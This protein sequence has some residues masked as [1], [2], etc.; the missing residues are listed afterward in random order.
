[1]D[2]P[3][4]MPYHNYNHTAGLQIFVS[5]NSWNSVIGSFLEVDPLHAWLNYTNEVNGTALNTTAADL[6]QVFQQL[7]LG[8]Q[9]VGSND[10]WRFITTQAPKSVNEMQADLLKSLS[11]KVADV[12]SIFDRDQHFQQGR[13]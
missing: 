13:G 10:V 5:D 2:F 7:S 6:K 12:R 9:T 8:Q 11:E 3:D 1:M 4:N